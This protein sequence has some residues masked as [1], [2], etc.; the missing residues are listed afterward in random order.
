MGSLHV[1][2]LLRNNSAVEIWNRKGS[3]GDQ[4]REARVTLESYE[5]FEVGQL[6]CLHF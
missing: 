3:S 1:Y 5:S 6:S 4:W 2:T